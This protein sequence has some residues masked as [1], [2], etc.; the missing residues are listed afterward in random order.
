MAGTL[1]S[2]TGSIVGFIFKGAGSVIIFLGRNTLLLIMGVVI[3]V[4]KR[5]QKD[6]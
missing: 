6:K 5:L 2:L 4:V 3:F 1:L